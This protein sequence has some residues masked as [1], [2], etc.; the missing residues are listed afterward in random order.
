[1]GR[2]STQVRDDR[3]LRPSL[4][5]AGVWP[6]HLASRRPASPRTD[7]SSADALVRL[8]APPALRA[9]LIHELVGSF[10][11]IGGL[12]RTAVMRVIGADRMTALLTAGAGKP[13]LDVA[14]GVNAKAT[15]T[16]LVVVPEEETLAVSLSSFD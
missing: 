7:T 4:L 5:P 12:L 11:G 6:G 10:G 9:G 1:V 14:G 15:V 16:M 3:E 13:V 8:P 2:G